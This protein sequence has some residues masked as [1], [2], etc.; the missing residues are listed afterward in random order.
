MSTLAQDH[1]VSKRRGWVSTPGGPSPELLH[2]LLHSAAGGVPPQGM[3]G[4]R[5]G[6]GQEPTFRSR[7]WL[8]IPRLC[9]ALLLCRPQFFSGFPPQLCL[10][11]FMRSANCCKSQISN[12]CDLT[13]QRL[14]CCP[15]QPGELCSRQSFRDP[16]FFQPVAPP[17]PRPLAISPFR[18]SMQ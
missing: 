18:G 16:G 15:V 13:Q 14:I 17:S 10:P 7:L 9:D 1:T 5:E 2:P 3:C 8:H 12:L 6:Q 4:H 11:D